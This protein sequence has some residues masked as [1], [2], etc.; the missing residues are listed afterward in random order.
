MTNTPK[1]SL[2]KGTIINNRYEI[3]R[4]ISSGGFGITYE[5]IDKAFNA[6]VAIKE[7]YIKEK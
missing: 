7:L 3:L 5:A 4:Y 1:Y 2:K 6:R